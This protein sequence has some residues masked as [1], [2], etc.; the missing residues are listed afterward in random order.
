MGFEENNLEFGLKEHVTPLGQVDKYQA[1]E[2]QVRGSGV[3][4]RLKT[5]A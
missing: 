5:Q 3:K 4:L 2:I 1:A